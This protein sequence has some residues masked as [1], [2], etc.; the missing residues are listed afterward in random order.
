M[1]RYRKTT[2][3]HAFLPVCWPR[4]ASAH[5][6]A[7]WGMRR[8]I[9]CCPTCSPFLELGTHLSHL[10]WPA[11]SS[12]LSTQNAEWLR[13]LRAALPSAPA[14]LTSLLLL[15]VTGLNSTLHPNT[16]AQTHNPQEALLWALRDLE[17]KSFKLFKF[18]LWDGSLLEGQPRLARGGLEGLGPVAPASRPVSL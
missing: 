16:M 15:P 7:Q 10:P 11:L 17:E 9:P 14:Y 2:R 4:H 6:E 8:N 1:E 3:P 12:L 18:H 13:C 5:K